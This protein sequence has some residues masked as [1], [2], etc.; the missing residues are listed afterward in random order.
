MLDFRKTPSS[1]HPRRPRNYLAR[2]ERWRLW[3][4]VGGIM[5]GVILVREAPNLVHLLTA[6]V[7]PGDD[8]TPVDTRIPPTASSNSDLPGTIVADT[9]GFKPQALDNLEQ[10]RRRLERDIWREQIETLDL[11]QQRQLA[12]LLYASR[13]HKPVAAEIAQ[14]WPATLEK[15]D[16][17]WRDY[18]STADT[19]VTTDARLSEQDR[20]AWL[21]ILHQMRQQ[22]D[23]HSHPALVAAANPQQLTSQQREQLAAMESLLLEMSINLIK[24]DTLVNWPT[25]SYA[26]FHLM[27]KLQETEP[28]ALAAQGATEVGFRMLDSQP[29]EYRMRLV[30]VRGQAWRVDRTSAPKNHLG[31]QEYYIIYLWPD[32][33]PPFPIRIY[34]LELPEGFPP[35]RD[36]AG[37]P[38]ILREPMEVTG[39][40]LKRCAY[41]AVDESRRAPLLLAKRPDWSPRP[42]SVTRELPAWQWMLA[43]A[44]GAALLGTVVA[45]TVLRQTRATPAQKY[46]PSERVRPQELAALADEP[47]SF[48]PSESLRR[49]AE[50]ERNA[51]SQLAKARPPGED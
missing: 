10:A 9:F 40:F 7:A 31:I 24:D 17:Q 46:A 48:S 36:E 23:E 25:D 15:L 32:G 18:A 30:R 44:L 13:E 26:W 47:V 8:G 21:I 3:L 49:L 51:Q 4:I 41:A 29:D 1:P 39:F 12:T 2:S 38:A 22:W 42:E 27:E 33:G 5:L 37:K 6:E 50:A 35:L 45:V 19:R 34:S 20:G 28:A 43:A 11:P 14:A 16:A